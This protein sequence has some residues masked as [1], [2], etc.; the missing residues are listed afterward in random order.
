M[1]TDTGGDG[2]VEKRTPFPAGDGESPDIRRG[3]RPRENVRE[4]GADEYIVRLPAAAPFRFSVNRDYLARSSNECLWRVRDGRVIRALAVGGETVVVEVAPGDPGH[5]PAGDSVDDPGCG[6]AD[7]EDGGVVV[8]FVEAADGAIPSP[9]ARAGASAFVREWLDLDRDLAPFYAMARRDPLLAPAVE[10]FH[11]LRLV[12]I[13]DLFEALAWSV[14][15]QQINMAYA[16]TLKRRFVERFGRRVTA[17][18][19]TL[20]LFPEPERIASLEAAD[21][22]GMGLST[23]KGEY[24]IHIAR[25]IAEGRLSKERLREAGRAGGRDAAG[26]MLCAIRG[27]GPWTAHYALMFCLRFPDAFPIDDVGLHNAVKRAAGLDR[28]PTKAELRRL[29]AGWAGWEAYA[30]FYLWRL[31]Y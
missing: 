30:T 6:A 4:D 14:I 1:R 16:Y 27:V 21:L 29:A 9:Q 26:S 7:A 12:G 28:K 8:R 20:W 31:L 2:I 5:D 17:G 13:P 11:G 3:F 19:E 24:L 25:L 10:A 18:G 22:Q 23:R 15:G